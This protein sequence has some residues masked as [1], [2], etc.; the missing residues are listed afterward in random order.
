MFNDPKNKQDAQKTEPQ[1]DDV[2][3]A[4]KQRQKDAFIR[5]LADIRR[6]QGADSKP[7]GDD[8]KNQDT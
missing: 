4:E 5:K 8:P 3:E 1:D 7:A 2:S 6:K